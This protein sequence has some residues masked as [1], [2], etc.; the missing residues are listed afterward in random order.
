MSYSLAKGQTLPAGLV[1]YDGNVYGTPKTASAEAQT[2]K[3]TV[4]GQNQTVAEF[5]LIISSVEK[6][7]PSFTAGKAGDAYAGKTLADVELP[8]SA[9]G[10]YMW[11]DGTQQVGKGR[12][13]RDLRCILC[14]R[15]HSKL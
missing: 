13:K 4:R 9:A 8:T 7:I 10:K 15:R 2:V 3:F 5:T 11:A 12:N 14:S 1:I 6:G